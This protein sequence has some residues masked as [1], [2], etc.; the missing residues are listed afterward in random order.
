MLKTSNMETLKSSQSAKWKQFTCPPNY[1]IKTFLPYANND[2]RNGIQVSIIPNILHN[3]IYFPPQFHRI[4][5][6]MHKNSSLYTIGK[7]H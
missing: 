7:K 5:G 6:P 1:F 4:F 2:N 3:N